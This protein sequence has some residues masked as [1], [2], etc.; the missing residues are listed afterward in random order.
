MTRRNAMEAVVEA[1][2]QTAK[3]Q[4]RKPREIARL[5]HR[6]VDLGMVKLM[7][8]AREEKTT[9]LLTKSVMGGAR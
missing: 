2:R 5:F 1:M 3:K 8:R 9:A 7:Q 4:K 6:Y